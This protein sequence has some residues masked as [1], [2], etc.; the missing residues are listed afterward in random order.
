MITVRAL[1]KSFITDR[2]RIDVLKDVDLDIRAGERIAVVGASGAGKTTLMHLLGG[3]DR[4]SSGSVHFADKNIFHYSA[5]E[6]D[7]FRNRSIGFVFQFH[8]LLPEF[9]ALENVMMPALIGRSTAKQAGS[10][11]SEI[12]TAVGLE[13]RL[14]HKPG[15]L[16][17]GEQQRVAIARSLIMSPQLLLADEPTGNL[18]S[19]TSDEILALLD[20]LHAER[21]LTIIVVTHS[22]KVA[23]HMDRIVRMTDGFL[24]G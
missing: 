17:G 10:R 21:D 8:Q 23:G 15:Q 1:S 20:R 3:L 9:S 6:L 16:S 14:D 2:G 12:L 19:S 5:Q 13:H 22:E 18:D 7:A 4:P 11:A 24:D